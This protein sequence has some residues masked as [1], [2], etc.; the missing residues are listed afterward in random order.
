MCTEKFLDFL[1]KR[2]KW[3]QKHI[4]IIE[5]ISSL[6][7]M[8]SGDLGPI[9]GLFLFESPC[10]HVR[11]HVYPIHVCVCVWLCAVSCLGSCSLWMFDVTTG[12]RRGSG[13]LRSRGCALTYWGE[14]GTD[15]GDSLM[16]VLSIALLRGIFCLTVCGASILLGSSVSVWPADIQWLNP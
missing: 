12:V 3:E 9:C 13:V 15:E 11:A 8:S 16:F 6:H 7:Y 14:R 5:G 4:Y 2:E 1:P 10:T